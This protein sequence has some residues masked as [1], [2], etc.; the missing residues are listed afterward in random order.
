MTETPTQFQPQ[1]LV[2]DSAQAVTIGSADQWPGSLWRD[3]YYRVQTERSGAWIYRRYSAL[4]EEP[5]CPVDQFD[6]ATLHDWKPLRHN[7]PD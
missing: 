7:Q 2:T 3:T 5:I 4:Q 6:P 1:P